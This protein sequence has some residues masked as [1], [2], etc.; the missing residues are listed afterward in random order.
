MSGVKAPPKSPHQAAVDL[1]KDRELF[2]WDDQTFIE[3]IEQEIEL[4]VAELDDPFGMDDHHD[5]NDEC[6]HDHASFK[7]D[8]P[9]TY[10][11]PIADQARRLHEAHKG[12]IHADM[13]LEFTVLEDRILELDAQRL[14]LP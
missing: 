1:L 13:A 6:D 9:A 3:R 8:C 12:I 10:L 5:C 14:V 2:G 7:E 4:A 11:R